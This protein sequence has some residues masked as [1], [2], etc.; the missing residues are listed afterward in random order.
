MRDGRT[1]IA[2]LWQYYGGPIT[3]V[4][5]LVAGFDREK[6]EVMFVY[7]SDRRA[8]KQNH[9]AAAGFRTVYLSDRRMSRGPHPFLMLRLARLLRSE[10][11]DILH[12]HAHKTTVYGA[13]A[14]WLARTPVVVAHIHGLNRSRTFRRKLV[15]WLISPRIDMFLSVSDAVRRD[16]VADNWGGQKRRVAVLE[17]SIDYGRFSA[18]DTPRQEA[19]RLL[20]VSE[21][22]FVFGTV[23]RLAPTKGLKYMLA[24]FA[25]VRKNVPSAHLVIVG[26]GPERAELELQAGAHGCADRVH[27]PGYLREIERALPGMDVFVLASIA[28]GMGRAILEAMAAGILCIGTDVG[29]IPEVLDDG[30]TGLLVPPADTMALADAMAKAGVMSPVEREVLVDNARRRVREAFSHDGAREKLRAIYEQLLGGKNAAP[31]VTE[32]EDG[33]GKRHNPDV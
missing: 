20:G 5:D 16:F 29:G 30:R 28:E 23:G 26:D 27:F 21:D 11:V 12:C 15:N 32:S 2:F 7:L 3:S 31:D 17:N 10:G 4:D 8:D 13:L 24:A 9:L 19:R 14:A 6:Y 1:K 18:I 22:A 33:K 25:E